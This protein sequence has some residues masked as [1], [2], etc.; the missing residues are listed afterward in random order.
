M[1]HQKPPAGVPVYSVAFGGPFYGVSSRFVST[2][3]PTLGEL[4]AIT[5]GLPAEFERWGE[6]RI[7]DHVILRECWHVVRPKPG[8]VAAPVFVTLH[9]APRG[10]GGSGS[11]SGG[12]SAKS[13]IGIVAALALTVATAGIAGGFLG[14]AL[15][16]SAL[17]A[18][19]LGAT[20]L[21]AGVGLAGSLAVAAL[22]AAPAK[23]DTSATSDTSDRR[24]S[25]SA[26]GNVVDPGGALPRVVGT[27]RVFPPF[28]NGPY[29]QI[30]DGA[31]YVTA[32]CALAG[33]HLLDELRI[34]DALAAESD[35]IETETREGWDD[36]TPITLAPKQCR[37]TGTSV[38]LSEHVLDPDS[39][40]NLAHQSTPE[41]DLPK[42]HSVATRRSPDRAR[43]FLQCPGGIYDT[44]D[45]DGWYMFPI[46][47]QI[48]RRG[49]VSWIPLPELW[50]SSRKQERVSCAITLDWTT[51]PSLPSVPMNRGMVMA[52]RSVPAQAAPALPAMGG[53]TAH[54]YFGTSGSIFL[55]NTNSTS[56]GIAHTHLS[57][58]GAT[59]YLDPAIFP[60]GIYDVQVKRGL[61]IS[62]I[63]LATDYKFGHPS[64]P[65]PPVN[66]FFGYLGGGGLGPAIVPSS[67][68][69][70]YAS[71][72]IVRCQSEWDEHP[73]QATGDAL[74]AVRARNRA[75]ESISV[76]ASG[77]VQDWDG[78]AWANWT[79]TANPAPHYR[80]VQSGSL[81]ARPLPAAL[82]DDATLLD[83]RAR[84]VAQDYRCDAIFQG[85]RVQDVLTT[86]AA[87]AYARPYQSELWGVVMDRDSS[88]EPPVQVFSPRNMRGF[89]F[90]RAFARLPDGFRVSY[91]SVDDDYAEQQMVVF[92]EGVTSGDDLEGVTYEGLVREADVS[93]RAAFD[94][95]QA[96]LRSTFYY[97]EASAEAIV[98]RR[99]DLV[100]VTHDV[101]SR[102]AGSARVKARVTVGANI[103]GLVLDSAM[104]VVAGDTGVVIRRA[105]GSFATAQVAGPDGARDEIEFVTPIP[106]AL[107]WIA[108]GHA[109]RR[110]HAIQAG[111]K[112][113]L[114]VWGPMTQE[115]RRMLVFDVTPGADGVFS[116]TFVDE[117]PALWA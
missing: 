39:S 102:Q 76:L 105:D 63:Y 3:G 52:W 60:P 27:R 19:S 101:L 57:R 24:G 110:E 30:I 82:I 56:S 84:C 77:Y 108:T 31:E 48:R 37:I 61:T 1:I 38:Q 6:V 47:V 71:C 59:F 22:T 66:D 33:Q 67:Q 18:G 107:V 62:R 64:D 81:N 20:V 88:A 72:Y 23:S 46:R 17:G 100:G 115:Y 13:I 45:T 85:E 21:A 10:G 14:T 58:D 91:R 5:P 69:N 86:I 42:W 70:R 12:S 53:W 89:R 35:D 36:D 8:T 11:G 7:C 44:D 28:V 80:A 43:L 2:Y 78:S 9:L 93:G 25:A 92:R 95:R 50:L 54:S 51:E 40:T 103:T 106:D 41:Q 117:A 49:D 75:I 79:T 4:I 87:C 99:G 74:I 16:I 65:H 109:P 83:W 15:G 94:L 32:L 90:E 29:Y 73:V 26:D 96:V 114:V 111:R 98:C 97:G 104:D 113:A 68:E 34:G 55:N 112:G 116:L